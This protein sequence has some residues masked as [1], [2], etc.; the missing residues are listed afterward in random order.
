MFRNS[1]KSLQ[2][3]FNYSVVIIADH[4]NADKMINKDGSSAD[5]YY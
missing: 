1:F 4:G 3:E 5:P 2:G